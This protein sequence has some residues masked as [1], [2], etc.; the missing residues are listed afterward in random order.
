M[1]TPFDCVDQVWDLTALK[2]L[3]SKILRPV[4]IANGTGERAKRP[5]VGELPGSLPRL[6]IYQAS[7][8][9]RADL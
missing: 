7:K 6:T 2:Q 3:C 9:A 1:N 5:R 4:S 8:C